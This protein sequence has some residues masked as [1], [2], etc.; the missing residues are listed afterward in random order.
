ME[1]NPMPVIGGTERSNQRRRVILAIDVDDETVTAI[2]L[3]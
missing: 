3:P 1:P 2:D